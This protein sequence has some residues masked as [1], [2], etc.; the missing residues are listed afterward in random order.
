MFESES[1]YDIEVLARPSADARAAAA[2]GDAD[3][4]LLSSEETSRAITNNLVEGDAAPV[5]RI[6]YVLVGPPDDPAQVGQQER[7]DDAFGA[8][9]GAE[10]PFYSR[11]DGSDTYVLELTRW[12]G[13]ISPNGSWYVATGAPMA[14]T[15][16]A[17]S[18]TDAYT[19]SD[20]WTFLSRRDALGL[21]ILVDGDPATT[22]TYSLVVV[23]PATHPGANATAARSFAAFLARAD[24]Q[25]I[26]GEY[27]VSQS[28]EPAF[29]LP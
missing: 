16:Q 26:I 6:D 27:G 17:A 25:Q 20:R 28:G 22:V 24:V 2:L 18:A 4:A 19:F 15:L 11:L 12:P 9:A 7:L 1:G 13:G 8:I 5:L 23:D 21:E 29:L 14:E 3:A 10:S